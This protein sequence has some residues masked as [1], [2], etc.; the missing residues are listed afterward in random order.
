MNSRT[1]AEAKKWGRKVKN[2]DPAIWDENK[3]DIVLQGS[4][5]KF[6]SNLFLKE[7]LMNTN[8]RILV[9]ASPVDPIWGIGLAKDHRD[10]RNP[11]AWRGENLLGFA[12]MEVRDI[13][14]GN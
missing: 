1:P 14:S 9:E 10:C 4:I 13:L 3:Y 5:H 7:Y 11:E 8:S 2:F 12:L 6:S